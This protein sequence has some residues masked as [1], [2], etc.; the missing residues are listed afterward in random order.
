MKG[1]KLSSA[2]Y[3]ALW[4][5][6]NLPDRYTQDWQFKKSVIQSMVKKGYICL[7][8]DG[9]NSVI[10]VSELGRSLLAH[11]ENLYHVKVYGDA[12]HS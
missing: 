2:Q 1:L 3:D 4:Q 5:L 9:L 12:I 8:E 6:I 11:D 10:R 7:E